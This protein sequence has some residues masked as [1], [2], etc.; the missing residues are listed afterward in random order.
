MTSPREL[1]RREAD[2]LRKRI[3]AHMS[4]Y[5]S[6]KRNMLLLTQRQLADMTGMHATMISNLEAG[7]IANPSIVQCIMLAK[8][9]G[10]TLGDLTGAD[11]Q[12]G[13]KTT[14]AKKG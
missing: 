1:S 2:A 5:V 14:H 7:A 12:C 3:A 9:L 13:Q 4:E 11:V 6:I 10:C 8:A